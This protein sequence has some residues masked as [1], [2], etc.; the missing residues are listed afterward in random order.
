[1]SDLA[2]F[3]KIIHEGGIVAFP[4]ET[5]YGLGADAW[6]PEAIQRIFETKGRPSD[7]PLIVH[8]S[9]VKEAEDFVEV[10]P[11]VAKLLMKHFW[12]GPLTF[13]LPKKREVLD[14]VTAGLS[15]VALRIP[16]HP[17]ALEFIKQTGPLVGPSANRSGKPSPT[18]AEHVKEDFGDD[19]PIIDGGSTKVGLESTVIGFQDDHII[20]MRPGKIGADEL[21]SVTGLKII[22]EYTNNDDTPKS[23]GQ[24]YSHYKPQAHVVYKGISTFNDHTMYLMQSASHVYQDNVICYNGDLKQLSKELYDRFR[25]ADHLGY[26]HIHIE[27]FDDLRSRYPAYYEALMNRIQKTLG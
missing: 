18:K 13:V 9:N 27:P 19:F 4:T 3:V 26:K 22:E 16:S 20:I 8:L 21:K 6:D 7:N 23:P 12:P 5:V 24:K 17:K 10:I 25:Q 1:M 11:E 15:T 14:S 2:P